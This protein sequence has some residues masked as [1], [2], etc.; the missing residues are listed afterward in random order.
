MLSC[1]PKEQENQHLQTICLMNDDGPQSMGLLKLADALADLAN[2][3]VIVPDG[4]RSG[5]GKALTLDRPIRIIERTDSE[6]YR[7]IVHDGL[8]A[9]SAIIALDMIE[10]VDLFVSGINAGANLGY[11]RMLTRGT[12]GAVL[13][14]AL[15]GYPAVAV[16]MVVSPEYWFA[17]MKNDID[18]EQTCTI[19]KGIIKRVLEKG[20]HQGISALNV[21]FPAI[22]L[23]E[24][25]LVVIEPTPV[26][27]SNRLEKRTDPYGSSYYWIQGGEV[28]SRVSADA[29]EVLERGNISVSPIVIDTEYGRRRRSDGS[30]T[31]ANLHCNRK[32]Y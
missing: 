16:S 31:G 13:E 15:Q 4:Q 26:A 21:N 20:L 6:R 14:A 12:V 29:L 28:E 22:I 30:C 1:P 25:K 2:L 11:H 3:I 24:T 18:L 27:V 10:K 9:D 19:T 32:T 17:N 5:T 23:N 7:L 8:P